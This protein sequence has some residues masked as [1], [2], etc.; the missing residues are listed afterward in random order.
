VLAYIG[1][2]QNA[3]NLLAC[4]LMGVIGVACYIR[5]IMDCIW[6]P[7][8]EQSEPLLPQAARPATTG[9][10]ARRTMVAALAMNQCVFPP[11]KQESE[12]PI[13]LEDIEVGPVVTPCGH[14][15]HYDCLFDWFME[16]SICPV[17]RKQI[18]NTED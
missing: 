1:W 14:H 18:G 10:T 8:R 4:L 13:C 9:A 11:E 15:F 3:Q 12:C 17:C 2:M 7:L 16:K 6:R 5:G